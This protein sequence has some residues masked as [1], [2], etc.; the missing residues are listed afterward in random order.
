[1]RIAWDEVGNRPEK[2]LE[3]TN[4]DNTK[5]ISAREAAPSG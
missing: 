3:H 2:P 1:M 4:R 5:V